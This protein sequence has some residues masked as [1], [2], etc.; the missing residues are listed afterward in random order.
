MCWKDS[1]ILYCLTTS[2]SINE[3]DLWFIKIQGDLIHISR[4][5]VILYYNYNMGGV[6]IADMRRLDFNSVI[7]GICQWWMKLFYLLDVVYSNS[8]IIYN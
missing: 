6:D 2:T 3:S 1:N 7:V 4:S 5:N 8:L